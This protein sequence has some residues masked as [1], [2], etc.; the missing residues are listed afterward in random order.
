MSVF[1]VLSGN[2]IFGNY[3][4]IILPHD[5]LTLVLIDEFDNG[6]S[7]LYLY[8]SVYRTNCEYQT[9]GIRLASSPGHWE[10]LGPATEC[11]HTN[12]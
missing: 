7:L 6:S 1:A 3:Y 10:T 9:A 11:A 5:T 4:D 8:I 12:Q 2:T